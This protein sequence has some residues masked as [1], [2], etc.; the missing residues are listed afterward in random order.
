M[1]YREQ[2]QLPNAVV[3]GP[4]TRKYGTRHEASVY[5]EWIEESQTVSVYGLF[6]VR[7]RKGTRPKQGLGR[8]HRG[9]W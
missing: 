9:V 1:Q 7:L 2:R 3:K 8:L 6:T 5:H 4:K